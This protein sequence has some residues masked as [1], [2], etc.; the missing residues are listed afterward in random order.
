VLS[1]CSVTSALVSLVL[2]MGETEAQD[3]NKWL[4]LDRGAAQRYVVLWHSSAPAFH[5]VGEGG[6]MEP[7]ESHFVIIV[8]TCL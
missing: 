7:R 6:S 4:G 3:N 1:W 2:Q 8:I 5:P